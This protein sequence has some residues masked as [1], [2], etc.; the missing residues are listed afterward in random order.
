MSAQPPNQP[1]QYDLVI[2]SGRI[3][4]GTRM[5]TFVG[6]LAIKDGKVAALGCIAGTGT[7]EIDARGLVVAP[8]FI[9]VHTHY[10]AQLNWDPYASQSC[11]HGITSIVI[12]A[13]GFGFSPCKPEDRE[14]AMQRMTRVEA[15][16]YQSMKEGMRWDWVSQRDYLESLE[17]AGLGVNVASYIPQSPIRAWVLGEEDTRRE[18]VTPAELEQMKELV[19][20][21]YRAGALGLST[22]LNL[23]DR[24]FDG[25]KLPSLIASAAETEALIAVARE[26]NVGSIEVTPESLHLGPDEASMLERWAEISGRP[27]YY[28]A[29]LQVHHLPGQWQEALHRLEDMNTRHRI[30]ALGN[31]HRIES[32]FNLVD[33]N[34][35]DDMP[36]W[37]EA[38][39]CS[40]EQRMANLRSPA[41]RAKLQHDLD[42]Y[43]NRLW[44]GNWERMKVFDSSQSEYKGRYVGEIARGQGLSP[45]DMFCEIALGEELKTLFLIEDLNNSV[46]EAVGEIVSHPFVIPGLSDG[47]AH[48]QF[49]C[50]GKYPTVMLAHWVRDQKKLSLEEAHW[51]LSHMSAAAIGL[52]GLGTLQPGMPADIVVYDL[53]ALKVT[54]SEPVYEDIIGGG[55]RLIQKAEGYRHILV[56][57]VVTFE[58]GVCTGEL[59]G[60]V[61]RTS[62]YVPRDTA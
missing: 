27:V 34:L 49:L 30:F 4:D 14:R 62:S 3:V 56:N 9:D 59:P 57:G 37:N 28:N 18:T 58:D 24:D 43:T 47:G 35:F 51:R 8:G 55:K 54:P 5:P 33:Y 25:S 48:T 50:L 52:E 7:R 40:M 31:T 22:D 20:E 23:I 19:R 32:L 46:D 38:L 36:A 12:A 39:A 60:R 42:H 53:E 6:D 44:A 17:R 2:R 26:F 10:D 11:W 45:L 16:P 21:G 13:C 1:A 41:V 61:L 29:I 15:I